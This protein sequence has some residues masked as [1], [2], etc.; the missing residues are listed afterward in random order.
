MPLPS[1]FLSINPRLHNLQAKQTGSM[2]GSTRIAFHPHAVLLARAHFAAPPAKWAPHPQPAK[3]GEDAQTSSA[4]TK[5]NQQPHGDGVDRLQPAPAWSEEGG[6][7]HADQN[8][9][10]DLS[11]DNTRVGRAYAPQCAHP[12]P[13]P[14]SAGSSSS[15]PA[16][17]S[18]LATGGMS[19]G[20]G[21]CG[22]NPSSAMRE[23]SCWLCGL[24]AVSNLSP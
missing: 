21:A 14:A 4:E 5:R 22:L 8:G 20:S 13:Q 10:T 23:R 3:D 6:E 12:Q 1:R 2:H 11:P 16:G 24:A 15:G 7:K 9:A 18:G 17:K 19:E